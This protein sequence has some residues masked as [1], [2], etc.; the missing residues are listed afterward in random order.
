MEDRTQ[1]N[2]CAIENNTHN[3]SVEGM[4]TTNDDNDSNKHNLPGA[5]SKVSPA[6]MKH[7]WTDWVVECKEVTTHVETKDKDK[8]KDR[9]DREENRFAS[10]MG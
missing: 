6:N 3:E 4:N 7:Q 2:N 9:E 8:D 1:A 5:D 10:P